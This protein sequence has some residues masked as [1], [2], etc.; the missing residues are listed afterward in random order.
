MVTEIK[1]WLRLRW[2]I[3]GQGRFVLTLHLPDTV[4]NRAIAAARSTQIERDIAAGHF[5]STLARYRG[6][7][8]AS[9][10]T[11]A[12]LWQR[13]CAA[14]A[15][16]QSSD[17]TAEK[18]R[19]L[20]R[21]LTRLKLDQVLVSRCDLELAVRV[22][23]GLI[24]KLCARTVREH[25]GNLASC[26]RWAKIEPN[27]WGEVRR[28]LD[29]GPAGKPDPFTPT[30]I[31]AI[32][33]GFEQPDHRPYLPYIRFL[34]ATGARTGEARGLRWESVAEDFG[35]VT[36]LGSLDRKGRWRSTKTGRSR[37]VILPKSLA[38][39]LRARGRGEPEALVFPG[40]RGAPLDDHNFANRHW[41]EVLAEQGVR[42][43]KPYRLRD[44]AVSL[45]L[46]AGLSPV[47]IAEQTGHRV[48]T[49]YEHYAGSISRPALPDFLAGIERGQTPLPPS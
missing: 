7:E 4:A 42:H 31:A 6:G 38:E 9:G 37:V 36:I 34:L 10:E 25:L 14:R 21:H 28:G 47:A 18:Y 22:R 23:E 11:I 33:A 19:G 1:G 45:A 8:T 35:S 27:P 46:A 20:A 2:S 40:P 44:T 49:L 16:G 17:R 30:E 26:W 5:D 43:R 39:D 24:A 13:Y 41:R 12:A 48:R 32:L 15:K 3:R 29:P